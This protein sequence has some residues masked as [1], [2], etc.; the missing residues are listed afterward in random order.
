MT[1][2][3]RFSDVGWQIA[4]VVGSVIIVVALVIAIFAG[5]DDG[6]TEVTVSWGSG[7]LDG[8]NPSAA[9]ASSGDGRPVVSVIGDSFTAGTQQGGRGVQGWP[10]LVWAR[11]SEQGLSSTR[12]VDATG[13][14]GYLEPGPFG[15]TFMDAVQRAVA[16]DDDLV[17]VFGGTNDVDLPVDE[18]GSAARDT[19]AAIRRRAP[20]A[21]LIV[22]GPVWPGA[23]PSQAMVD[24][25]DVLRAVAQT[26]GATFVDPIQEAW[27]ADQPQLIGLDHVH[28]NDDG[29]RYLADHLFP[30]IDAALRALPNSTG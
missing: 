9:A 5:P 26:Q 11:L 8:P 30:V 3:A 6:D 27:F 20:S 4:G 19:M 12:T 7:E 29:H 28:P 16:P 13:G 21:A 23:S 17:V 14:S 18:L 25:R 22:V 2:R 24:V 10:A 15:V 1:S